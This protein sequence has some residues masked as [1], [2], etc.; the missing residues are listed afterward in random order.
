M[1]T[2][3]LIAEDNRADLILVQEALEKHGVNCRL[4]VAVDGE[5][6]MQFLDQI[7]ERAIPCPE[8]IILDLNLPKNSGYEVLARIR[9]R[10]LCMHTRVVILSSAPGQRGEKETAELRV[11]RY[12]QKPSRFDEY[13]QIG[14]ELKSVLA[15]GR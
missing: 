3:I 13:M 1:P 15:E 2:P 4:F 5:K 11:S 9:S 6:A 12:I 10:G 8:L 14:A 7:D